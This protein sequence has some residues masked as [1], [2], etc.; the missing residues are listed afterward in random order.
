MPK[1]A[2]LVRLRQAHLE[3][4]LVLSSEALVVGGIRA[5]IDRRQSMHRKKQGP[6]T[7]GFLH[8]QI[9]GRQEERSVKQRCH[10]SKDH[11]HGH[12]TSNARSMMSFVGGWAVI[13]MGK[14]RWRAV[15]EISLERTVGRCE[16]F[17]W[18]SSVLARIA[19]GPM[20]RASYDDESGAM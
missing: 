16:P 12:R 4:I 6:C 5:A 8:F 9:A 10:T 18:R 15:V 20:S 14:T 7:E 13:E 2:R 3:G 1:L 17:V 19:G 11:A